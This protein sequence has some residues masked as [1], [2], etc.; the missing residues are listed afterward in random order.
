MPETLHDF[1]FD[2][3]A[4]LEHVIIGA[5]YE[6]LERAVAALTVFS[7]PAVVAETGNRNLFR[8]RRKASSRRTV[9]ENDPTVVLDDNFGPHFVFLAANVVPDGRGGRLSSLQ[10]RHLALNHIY[11]SSRGMT[12]EEQIGRY[13]NLA[14]LCVSPAFLARTTD[15][16]PRI[17]E[18]L[19]FRAAELY[20]YNPLGLR[21]ENEDELRNLPWAD[22]LTGVDDLQ[23]EIRSRIERFGK[24]N[25]VRMA[26][27]CGGWCFDR[28][29]TNPLTSCPL[30]EMVAD[31]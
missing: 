15:A 7:A 24:T 17:I 19:Q 12:S 9:D 10:N 11:P 5:G 21:F 27:E 23:D 13:T 28:F 4:T 3:G 6:T 8:M 26:A 30:R 16:M 18:L 25:S 14:N 29:T 31:V 1:G 2:G 20:G 22:P